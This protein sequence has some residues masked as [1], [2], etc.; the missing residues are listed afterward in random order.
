[1]QLS[2]QED[3][4]TWKWTK[5]GQYTAKSAY[6]AQ[7]AGSFCLFD[8]MAIWRAKVEGKHR[9]FAWLMVQRKILTADKL[10]ARNW[11]CDPICQ[12]CDHELESAEHLCLQ[13]VYAQQ[14][15]LLVTQWTDGLASCSVGWWLMAGA[16]LF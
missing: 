6:A 14:V 3:T 9:F 15:W 2:E 12:L 13:C 1:V 8:S 10:L 7:L 4:I 11:P 5:H 16:D